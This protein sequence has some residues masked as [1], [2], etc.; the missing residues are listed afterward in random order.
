MDMIE[1]VARA[2]AME[3]QKKQG[4]ASPSDNDWMYY[5]SDARKAI[6]AMR[7]PTLDMAYVGINEN[8][9]VDVIDL[10]ARVW[11]SMVDEALK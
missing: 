7:W 4:Y 8:S 11:T 6:E 2:L 5:R 1:R 3:S 9:N 10:H